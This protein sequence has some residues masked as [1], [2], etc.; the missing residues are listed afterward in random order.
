MPAEW[1][2]NVARAD[3]APGMQM[4]G[5]AVAEVIDNLDTT[6]LGRVQLRLPWL[7]G[8]EPW[9]RVAAASAGPGRGAYFIPQIGEEVLVAF[10][11]GDVRDPYIV[12]TLWNAQ[13][14]PPSK[15]PLDPQTRR[16]IRTPVGHQIELDDQEQTV[17]V[18]T[19]TGQKL[20]LTP[21]KIEMTTTDGTASV[22]L[23]TTG[24][25][26]VSADVKIELKA[27]SITLNGDVEV[28]IQSSGTASIDGGAL[29]QV[30]AALVKIN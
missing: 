18:E 2:E 22:V 1:I 25:V 16:V 10:Q 4:L 28:K 21:D 5:V 20:T 11:H 24:S 8:V 15:T 14:R 12:G 3:G 6:S 9:A 23:E 19:S 29:C 7:P 13:D 27:P 30:Q 17:T 26:S